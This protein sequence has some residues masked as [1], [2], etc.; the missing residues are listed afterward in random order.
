MCFPLGRHPRINRVRCKRRVKSRVNPPGVQGWILPVPDWPVQ[1]YPCTDTP[2]LEDRDLEPID[3][4]VLG[5]R[6]HRGPPLHRKV[7]GAV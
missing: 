7:Q 3:E 4:R 2:P 6:P 1:I 5:P